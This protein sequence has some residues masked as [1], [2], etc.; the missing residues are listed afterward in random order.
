M[1]LQSKLTCTG[2]GLVIVAIALV[3]SVSLYALARS[4]RAAVAVSAAAVET[5]T[6]EVLAGGVRTDREMVASLLHRAENDV[7]KLAGSPNVSGFFTAR[8][9]VNDLWNAIAMR[10]AEAVVDS[11]VRMCQG[12]QTWLRSALTRHLAV[13][14]HVLG[15]HGGVTGTDDTLSWKAVNQLTKAESTVT[16]PLL[17]AGDDVFRPNSDPNTPTPIVDEVQGLVGG[18]CTLFQRMNDAGDML[19]IAT[20]VVSAAGKRAVGTYIPAV[21]PDGKPNSV[22]AEVL[23]GK[24]FVGRAFVVDAWCQT[25]YKPLKDADGR[26]VGML[27]VG[28]R[29]TDNVDLVNEIVRMK[30]GRTGYPFV[31]DSTGVL[32]VH[33]KKEYVG[34]NTITDL[35]LANFREILDKRKAGEQQL[36]RYEFEG[37]AKFVLYTYFAP[38]DWV[39]CVSGYWDELVAGATEA[40]L[41]FLRQEIGELNRISVIRGAEGERPLYSQIRVLDSGGMELVKL[42]HGKLSQDLKDKSTASWFA[43]TSSLRPG[44]VSVAPLEIAANTGEPELRMTMPVCINGRTYGFA[45]LSMDWQATRAILAGRVYGKTGYPYIVNEQGVVVTHPRYTLKDKIS[46]ADPQYGE[47]SRL[48]RERMCKGEEGH[49]RYMFEG[50]EKLVSFAPLKLGRRDYC[51]AVTVPVEEMGALAQQIASTGRSEARNAARTIAVAAAAVLVVAV[52]VMLLVSRRIARPLTRAVAMLQ[53]IAQ[54]EGD[55]TRR[56][57][58]TTKDE[59]GQLAHW[60]N[61][62]LDKLQSL[63][64]SI[65]AAAKEF[66]AKAA[67]LSSTATQLA[68]GAATTSEQSSMAMVGVE[69][70]VHTIGSVNA[71]TGQMTANAKSAAAAVE[72]MTASIAEVARSAEHAAGVAASAARLTESSTARI[73]HLDAAATEIG[74]VVEVIQDIAEQ[75]N[76]LALNATIEAARAGDAGKGF[77][78][79]ATEVKELARQTASA[80]EDI[81]R[82]IEAIQG[83]TAET[84]KA[85]GEISDVIRNVNDVSRTIATAAEEQSITTKE[86]AQTVAQTSAAAESASKGLGDTAEGSVLIRKVVAEV[87]RVAKDTSAN[88]SHTQAVG[89]DLAGLAEQMYAL[90]GQ[91]RISNDTNMTVAPPETAGRR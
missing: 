12:Q 62:F 85:I 69:E 24:T 15:R 76:L 35:K 6:L 64:G 48:M 16:L 13:A 81:R 91:F 89:N 87:E 40:S 37:R 30:I 33:P 42:E 66:S 57:H 17:K 56:L 68:G 75:T 41:S 22:V 5:Q 7:R 31:M 3:A 52:V 80:T 50:V 25:A 39:V 61:T 1:R 18:T 38:W 23:A 45:V 14:E 51:L 70:M 46:L 36:L 8:A 67:E 88:A 84:V 27:Y 19:R 4:N 63:V 83:S 74:K 32:L 71:A 82:R 90:V 21:G 58:V 79:V 73:G 55:L 34:K 53:D 28:I 47:L 65:A 29:E 54:G 72:E 11:I 59:L 20:N 60:F 78:V 77:A 44:E 43:E 10:Q 26:I 49:G 9:G 86:I 2:L